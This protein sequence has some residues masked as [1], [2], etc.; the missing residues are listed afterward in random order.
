M[1]VKSRQAHHKMF[2]GH[3]GVALMAKP[4]APKTSLGTLMLASA[5]PD[6]LAFLFL[7]A[8]IEHFSIQPGITAAN[9]LNLYDIPLSHSLA[10]DAVW[11]ALFAAVYFFAR[12]YTRGALVA[13]LAVLSHWVLD[14]ASRRPDMSLAPGVNVYVGL[15]LY[16]SIRATLIVEGLVWLLGIGIYVYSTFAEKRAGIYA[17]WGM[18]ALVTVLWSSGI[19]G[20]PPPNVVA[21]EITNVIIFSAVVA[22]AYW[23]DHMRELKKPPEFSLDRIRF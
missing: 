20:P 1:A 13:F 15:G 14:L 17:F 9:A 18:V 4:L 19:A 10:M 3:F 22:W 21:V 8:G 6:L 23:I 11:G 12:R 5:L 2:I 16:D 7:I